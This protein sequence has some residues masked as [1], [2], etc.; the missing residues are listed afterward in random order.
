MFSRTHDYIIMAKISQTFSM[1]SNRIKPGSTL[2]K[3]Q[4]LIDNN[5]C[6]QLEAK[7]STL[8]SI[9]AG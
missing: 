3:E 2:K 6:D 5:N 1:I 7:T 8:L 4:K 9:N